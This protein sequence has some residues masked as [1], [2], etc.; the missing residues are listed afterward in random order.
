MFYLKMPYI[1]QDCDPDK[2]ASNLSS[3]GILM[4]TAPKTN[5]LENNSSGPNAIK[6]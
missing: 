6:H 2:V 3:D 5:A 1:F 4:V